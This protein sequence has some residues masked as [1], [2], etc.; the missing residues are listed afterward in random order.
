[1]K[2]RSLRRFKYEI[3][4][5]IGVENIS[6]KYPNYDINYSNPKELANSI[7]FGIENEGDIEPVCN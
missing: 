7:A 5:E 3:I 4:I 6:N 2:K 1:M